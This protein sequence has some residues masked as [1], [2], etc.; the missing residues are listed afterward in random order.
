M[1]PTSGKIGLQ[2]MGDPMPLGEYWLGALKGIPVSDAGTISVA[3]IAETAFLALVAEKAPPEKRHKIN[4]QTT[5]VTVNLFIIFYSF[6]V[7]KKLLEMF[8]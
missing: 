8:F 3:C 4:I 2:L 1:M 7:N 5:N 6:Q